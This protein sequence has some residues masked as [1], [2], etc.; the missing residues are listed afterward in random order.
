MELLLVNVVGIMIRSVW[1]EIIIS[2]VPGIVMSIE[3]ILKIVKRYGSN[4]VVFLL[5]KATERI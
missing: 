3:K 2:P 1:Q 4:V 5:C